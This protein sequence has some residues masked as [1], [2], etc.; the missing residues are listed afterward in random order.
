MGLFSHTSIELIEEF[1]R[2]FTAAK[3]WRE[4]IL[5]GVKTPLIISER[6]S[7]VISSKC[8]TLVVDE[9]RMTREE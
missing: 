8:D 7:W 5:E 6:R 9:K 3:Y 4:L 1:S 2:K